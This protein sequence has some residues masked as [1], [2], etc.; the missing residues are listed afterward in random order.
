MRFGR[1]AGA[2]ALLI[3]VCVV[4]Y[5][6]AAC[7]PYTETF[8]SCPG[9]TSRTATIIDFIQAM[10]GGSQCVDKNAAT[11]LIARHAGLGCKTRLGSLTACD[12]NRDG[13]YCVTEMNSKPCLC[14]RT[15]TEALCAMV[16]V[17]ALNFTG[18]M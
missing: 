17:Q 16:V 7:D 1:H 10:S 3:G 5:A 4:L 11:D 13:L 15:C 14:I 8:L 12:I 2:V 9:I 6:R 18:S